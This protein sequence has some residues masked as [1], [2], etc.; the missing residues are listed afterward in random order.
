MRARVRVFLKPSVFDPQGSTVAHA[1]KRVGF[2]E[3]TNVRIGKTIDL[4]LD[5]T[6]R[7]TA[8]KRVAAMCEKL[9]ANPVIESYSIEIS[10]EIAGRIFDESEEGG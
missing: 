4:E 8:K 7:E 1:L 6:D 10:G 9:L 2:E 5:S 3:V